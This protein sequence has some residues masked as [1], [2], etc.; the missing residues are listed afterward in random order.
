M[1]YGLVLSALLISTV[2]CLVCA[3]DDL[4]TRAE[5][6]GYNATSTSAEVLAFARELAARSND[7][8]LV[9]IGTSIRGN[10]IPMLILGRPA[11]RRPAELLRDNRLCVYIQ[12]NIHPGEVEGKEATLALARDIALG[13]HG[14][15][16]DKLVILIVPNLNPDGN[17]K[18][19]PRNRAYQGGPKD[20][21]GIRYNEQNLDL[22]RDWIK[23][24]TPEARAVVKVLREWD[25][26][27]L[28]DCH[29]TNGSYHRNPL[30]YAPPYNPSGDA[31]VRLYSRDELL[32]HMVRVL[33]EKFG[34]DSIPYGNFTNYT[35]PEKG[36]WGTFTHEPRYTSNYIGLRNRL[37][38]LIESYYLADFET[39]I[40][41]TYG[42]LYGA[43]EHCAESAGRIADL[44]KQADDRARARAAGIDPKRDFI[45][46]AVEVKPMPEPLV[47]NGYV[48]EPFTD[49][50]GRQRLRPTEELKTYTVPYVADF[51]P[52]QTRP[53]PFAYV[54]PL[55]TPEI[56]EKLMQHGIAVERLTRDVELQ[57]VQ[58]MPTEIKAEERAY[59]GHRF[60]TL[61]GDWR[62]Q[63]ARAEE[64]S[65][66]V[67]T[68]QPLGALAAYML[69]PESDDGLALY[70]FFDRLLAPQW[71]RGFYPYPVLRIESPR[72]LPTELL[73]Y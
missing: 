10:E 29:T 62:E 54:F 67:R 47:I 37:G 6:S 46:T 61:K 56:A 43:L 52:T 58:F 41:S 40:K 31:E 33:K 38:V 60:V 70:N 44:L 55:G 19:D 36:A 59:Q 3:A 8:R 66:V 26:A 64:G 13:E 24:E 51:V 21:V 1:R 63:T 12:A 7:V 20:G 49:D 34:Y 69:E 30:T 53:L 14:H 50:Q 27:L 15:F 65:F 45:A 17:D 72:T 39:R 11:P 73:P 71:G 35:E 9:S 48:M 22:N 23:L 28:V 57:V 5:S 42:F 2:C 16:L 68:A 18:I 4:L 32:P 25:P